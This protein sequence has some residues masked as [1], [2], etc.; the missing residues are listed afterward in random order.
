LKIADLFSYFRL[1]SI[2]I[3]AVSA[4]PEFIRR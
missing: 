4:E 2:L 1:L 3:E